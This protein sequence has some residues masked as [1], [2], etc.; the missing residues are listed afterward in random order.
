MVEISET[1]GTPILEIWLLDVFIHIF[2]VF[3]TDIC[4]YPDLLLHS[5]IFLRNLALRS[6]R[7]EREVVYR[8]VSLVSGWVLLR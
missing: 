8:A 1:D 4:P 6:D 2:H 3:L 5:S 7:I